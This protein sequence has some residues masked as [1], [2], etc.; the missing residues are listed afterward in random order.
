MA[1]I[2]KNTSI[3]QN[4][5]MLGVFKKYLKSMANTV[6]TQRDVANDFKIEGGNY[7]NMA[8]DSI[9]LGIIEKFRKSPMNTLSKASFYRHFG[10]YKKELN[11]K[12]T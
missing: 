8:Q 4:K 10:K 7:S 3:G 9:A 6:G 1:K 2:F 5:D 12:L 11:K